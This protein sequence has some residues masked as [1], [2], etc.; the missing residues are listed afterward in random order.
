[1]LGSARGRHHKDPSVAAVCWEMLPT[2]ISVQA[3]GPCSPGEGGKLDVRAELWELHKRTARMVFPV[4]R[5]CSFLALL[6]FLHCSSLKKLKKK[7]A[8]ITAFTPFKYFCDSCFLVFHV[9][10]YFGLTFEQ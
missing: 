3:L 1:M 5:N 4:P 7:N 10:V 9:S 2:C 6:E 8:S